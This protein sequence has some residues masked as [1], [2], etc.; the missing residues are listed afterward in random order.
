MKSVVSC[1]P[2]V[3]KQYLS[4]LTVWIHFT[5]FHGFDP[6]CL[7]RALKTKYQRAISSVEIENSRHAAAVQGGAQQTLSEYL[8][9]GNMDESPNDCGT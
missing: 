2:S 9:C 3:K 4:F 5:L 6:S 8:N 7:A 1:S